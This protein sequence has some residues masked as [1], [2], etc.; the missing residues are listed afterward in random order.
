MTITISRLYNDYSTAAKV[1]AELK[2][3][4]LREGEISIIA[5]NA[6]N[7]YSAD[8]KRDAK[9]TSG[10][11]DRDHDGTDD[12]AEGAATGA[13]VGAGVGSAV[14]LLAGLGLI[15]IPG[16][17]PVVAA[18]WLASTLAGTAAGAATGGIIGALSQAGVNDEDAHIYAE[19]V[20]R[21]GTL[22][23]ARVPDADRSR[24]EAILDR[25]AVDIRQRGTS[26]RQ[27]GWSRFDPN[28]APYTADQVRM[29]RQGTASAGVAATRTITAFFDNRDDT[30]AAIQRLVTAG[31]QRNEISM[32]EGAK[33]S[34][35]ST[36]S[37]R[38]DTGFWDS[39]KDF[40]L[41]DE[42]RQTYSEGLRRGG[43]LLT[44]RTNSNLYDR[45]LAILD[46]E[47]TV[48]LDQRTATWRKEGWQPR[49]VG[50][51]MRSPSAEREVIPVIE[52]QLKVGKRDVSHGRVR[53]RTYVVEEP[54][55]ESVDLREERVRVERRAVDRPATSDERLFQ[56]RT[57][58]AE[59]RAEEAVIEK[60]ARVK[61]EL[62]VRKDVDQRSKTVSDKVRHTEVKVEDERRARET[63]SERRR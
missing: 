14:G 24:F 31:V 45:A 16:I 49:A 29:A 59:E 50:T 60:Q 33:Q 56:N 61:E 18:G 15:A 20:R 32:V 34:S 42:D 8:Q 39:L 41:P 10:R 6:E 11:V 52:E 51:G 62:T 37:N 54:I 5:N 9:A 48:D 57:I 3:A 25:S 1:V 43:F 58:E 46:D 26:F 2:A 44:V 35:A 13:G 27:S 12:R 30:N 38:E 23:V 53:V 7:W 4:G 36:A 63:P 22:V 17:G 47:G 40:F 21:G 55:Q 28:A 19:G